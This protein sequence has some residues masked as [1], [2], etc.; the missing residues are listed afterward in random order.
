MRSRLRA[1]WGSLVLAVCVLSPHVALAQQAVSKVEA[2][3]M[4]SLTGPALV[5]AIIAKSAGAAIAVAV[6]AM[7]A[8][9]AQAR[10]GA[11]GAGTL[12][13]RPEVSIWVVTLQAL[14]EIIVLLGF[15]IAFLIIGIAT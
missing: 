11:A 6:A 14:P 1:V 3:K 13:E 7:S 5:N 9:Y 12:A 8:A 2:G 15:V 4:S 10:I